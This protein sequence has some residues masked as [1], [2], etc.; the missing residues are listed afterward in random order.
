VKKT[1]TFFIISNYNTD[2]ERYLSYCEDYHIYD[3]SPDVE[4]RDSLRHKYSKIS[5]VENTGHNISDYFRYFI[6]HYE[7]L[8]QHMM[9]AKGNMI[10]RHITQEYFDRIYDNKCYTSLYND[11]NFTDK[12]DVAYQLYDGAFL[13]VNNAWYASAKSH[14]YF[15]TYN[16][17]ISFVF[18]DPIIP[19]WLL[20]SPGACYIVSREQVLKYPKE[21]YENLKYL[22][23]YTYFPLEAYHVERMLQVIFSANYEI[24]P[25]ME[26]ASEFYIEL[27]LCKKSNQGAMQ[28]GDVWCRVARSMLGRVKVVYNETLRKLMI[29]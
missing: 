9:L 2:P 5:F 7:S 22:V 25:Y 12:T 8:P 27:E 17:L 10:G 21:F 3:Q 26:D 29:K 6:D 14:K 11:R 28:Q 24:N 15:K 13:E 23:S 20:F 1:S 19:H 16:D 18:K 4:I